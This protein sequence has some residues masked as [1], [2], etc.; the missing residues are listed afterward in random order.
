MRSITNAR[1]ERLAIGE[2]SGLTDVNIETI[3]Y[4]E[5]IK[6]L[7]AP[8]RTTG[9]RRSYD[10]THARILAFIRRSRE[11]GFSLDQVRALLRLG[12]P[13]RPRADRFATLLPVTST[14]FAQRSLI[15][16]SWRSCWQKRLHNAPARQHHSALCWTSSTCAGVK[17][18]CWGC[19]SQGLA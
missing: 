17:S 11:L 14:R 13:E 16:A 2:L 15:C 19:E 1:A 10:H 18:L 6:I 9:G 3:R 5:R 4:Y 8:P 7:P 12:G